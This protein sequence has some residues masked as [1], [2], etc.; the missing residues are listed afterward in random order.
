MRNPAPWR[1]AI[2]AGMLLAVAATA[3]PLPAS[4]QSEWK[5]SS[6]REDL[7]Y[8]LQILDAE[9][10]DIRA[11]L[12]GATAGGG[13]VTGG[14]SAAIEAE[15]RRLTAQVERVEQAQRALRDDLARRLGDIEFR[16]NE[17]EGN[18]TD[19]TSAPLAGSVDGPS[20]VNN[21]RPAA[22]LSERGDLDRAI[23]DVEQGRFDQAQDRLAR[24][25]R[26]YPDS[27]LSGE[28]YYWQ[29]EA[30]F[31]RGMHAEAARA[32][33]NGYN[34]DRRGSHAAQNLYR[35]GVTLGR[36]GQ[37][38]EACLT[39]REVRN[40]FPNAPDGIS[41]KADAEADQLACG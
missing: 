35:L 2:A 15:L 10:A 23:G 7:L 20:A 41:A 5:G 31:V 11:R 28:A 26:E 38:N 13:V 40:Q 22:A 33:L 8:R 16:L 32:Y 34:T 4:A 19:G 37:I 39:L 29:G 1:A 36:L 3:V 12:G 17:L 21:D 30:L 6:S 25:L 18:P 14:N 24:F 27:P 9:I